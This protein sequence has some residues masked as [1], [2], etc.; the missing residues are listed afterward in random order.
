MCFASVDY[1]MKFNLS[2]YII[3]VS[4]VAILIIFVSGGAFDYISNAIVTIPFVLLLLALLPKNRRYAI[5]I[6][7]ILA[8]CAVPVLIYQ[9][10]ASSIHLSSKQGKEWFAVNGTL[11]VY[12]VVYSYCI[13]LAIAIIVYGAYL[14]V[15]RNKR[16]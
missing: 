15:M 4:I 13:Y 11:T 1:P 9:W 10:I 12:G 16:K 6:A 3:P 5:Q 7:Y 8:F 14:F 2:E